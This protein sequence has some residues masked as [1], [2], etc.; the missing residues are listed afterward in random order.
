MTT[1]K[2]YMPCIILCALL[3]SGFSFF[4]QNLPVY[5]NQILV[6]AQATLPTQYFTV[7]VGEAASF[8]P[9]YGFGNNY[10]NPTVMIQPRFGIISRPDTET[11]TYTPRSNFVG[12]DSYQYQ[13]LNSATGQTD[14]G[15]VQIAV[16][17]T[18]DVVV[19]ADTTTA[20]EGETTTINVLGNDVQPYG[21]RAVSITMQASHGVAVPSLDGTV[22]YTSTPG[23]IGQ[24]IFTYQTGNDYYTGGFNFNPFTI[25]TYA[26]TSGTATVTINITSSGPCARTVTGNGQASGSSQTTF[27]S[28][29]IT[30]GVVTLYPGDSNPNND[31]CSNTDISTTIAFPVSPVIVEG[32]V[33]N[34][35]ENQISLGA[36]S[37]SSIR[38]NPQT[39]I[40]D[41]LFDDL[42]GLSSSGYTVTTEVSNF[43][44][45][46]NNGNV[47][48]LGSNSDGAS[49]VLDSGIV[50]SI[51][52][53]NGGSG[54]TTV[55]QITIS[56]GGG[57][58][59]TAIATVSGGVITKIDVK[60]YGT[61]YISSPTVVI[62]PS[63]G[64]TGA[65]AIAEIVAQDSNLN[66]QTSLPESTIF[67][68]LDP[69]VGGINKLKPIPATSP[70]NIVRGPRSLVTSPTTQYTLFSTTAPIATGRYDLDAVIFGLRTPSYLATG[71]YRAV[72]TQTIVVS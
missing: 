46:G 5:N 2:K 11:M 40:S 26:Q 47:I 31:I 60:N 30:G 35:V 12:N 57:T 67:A 49:A 17:A 66:P 7:V 25:K 24:D 68:T 8:S 61:N 41:I 51:R 45:N 63:G 32:V 65:T 53:T 28:V 19:N 4:N 70:A 34:G 13:I 1:L 18:Q 69:S 22:L 62:T 20:I 55:P 50:S 27:S 36:I 33:C 14:I 16:Q 54:Y 48:V 42:R 23:Y 39:T 56:G 15:S 21:D 9:N 58:G 43:V 37:T 6:S 3:I 52:I 71:D 59:A 10:H 29:C 44:D 72:I 64:G 38:Q